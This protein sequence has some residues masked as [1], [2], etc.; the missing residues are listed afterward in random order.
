MESAVRE[1]VTSQLVTGKSPNIDKA[2][3]QARALTKCPGAVVASRCEVPHVEV[4][5]RLGWLSEIR[6][7]AEIGQPF[8]DRLL[9]GP[10]LVTDGLLGVAPRGGDP[11]RGAA[12]RR[13]PVAFLGTGRFTGGI[14]GIGDALAVAL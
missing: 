3:K 8:I 10:E 14:E 1:V 4:L 5:P 11:Q 2:V 9:G 13:W 6:R 12:G 7:V